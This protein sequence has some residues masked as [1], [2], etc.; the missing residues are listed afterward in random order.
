MPLRSTAR[1]FACGVILLLSGLVLFGV[2]WPAPR[3]RR[4]ALARLGPAVLA[5]AQKS[6]KREIRITRLTVDRPGLILAEGVHVAH[7]ASLADGELLSAR[8]MEIRYN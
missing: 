8:R 2:W 3:Y 5:Q 4:L 7:G 6:L 1:R